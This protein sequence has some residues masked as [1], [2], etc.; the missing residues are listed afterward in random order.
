MASKKLGRVIHFANLPLRMLLP[1]SLDDVKEVA[2]KTIPSASK[3]RKA[4]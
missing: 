4:Q 3:V 2:F 1:K